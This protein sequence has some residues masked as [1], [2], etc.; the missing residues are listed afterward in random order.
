MKRLILVAVLL[1]CY[2]LPAWAGI[3]GNEVE[4][5]S[6]GVP[7]KGYLA[8]DDAVKGRRPGV[9]VVHEW[10]GHTEYARKRARMLAELGYVA[11][12]VDMFGE[13][14]TAEHPDEAKEFA[15]QVR[16]N[17]DVGSRRFLA[18][19]ELLKQQALADPERIAAIGYCFGGGIVLQMARDGLDLRGVVSF[20]GSL[21]SSTPAEKGRI[22]AAVLVCH[23]GDDTLIP[24]EHIQAFIKEML[25][26]GVFLRFHT[27]PG[28]RHSFTNPEADS[29]AE[30]FGMPVGYNK[31]ADIQS[32]QAM[33]DFFKQIFR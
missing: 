29:F 1:C 3:V 8:Y 7:L 33:S 19:L 21:A 13:G 11:L 23:G 28:A 9:L 20:H 14:K 32:W 17:M 4:Y 31:E 10:W 2:C 18:A 12:A 30:Q 15:S 24:L 25:E 22:K 26:A 5:S 16:N 27:Y 6:D